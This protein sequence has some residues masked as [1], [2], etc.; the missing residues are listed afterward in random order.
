MLEKSIELIFTPPHSATVKA[1][2]TITE[3]KLVDSRTSW[4][5]AP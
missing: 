1:K 5:F 3:I 4:H 2:K